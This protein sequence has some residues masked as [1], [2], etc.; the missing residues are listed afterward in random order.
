MLHKIEHFDWCVRIRRPKMHRTPVPPFIPWIN[1]YS[2]LVFLIRHVNC[3]LLF[4]SFRYYFFCVSSSVSFEFNCTIWII[5]TYK[6]KEKCLRCRIENNS[7]G[8]WVQCFSIRKSHVTQTPKNDSKRVLRDRYACVPSSNAQFRL[9]ALFFH[10]Y[11][12][13]NQNKPSSCVRRE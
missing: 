6:K 5:E 12:K 3:N 7:N 11:I 2:F 1:T 8:K 9:N 13:C 10:P 4:V